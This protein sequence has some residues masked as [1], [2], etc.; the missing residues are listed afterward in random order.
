MTA[1]SAS[2]AGRIVLAA[3]AMAML[4][5][6]ATLGQWLGLPQPPTDTER[7][8]AILTYLDAL[9]PAG[10]TLAGTQVNEYEISIACDSMDRLVAMTGEE[11]AMLGLELMFAATYDGYA[12][13]LIEH[14]VEHTRRGGLVTL[15]WHQ[16][17]P[18][19]V[20]PRGEF[21][22]CSKT[23]MSEDEL[24]RM[25]TPGTPENDLWKADVAASAETL[26]ALQEAGVTVLFRPY[27]EMSGDWFWWGKKSHFPQLWDALYDEFVFVHG[28]D[29]MI[30]V[31]SGDR[32]F[33]G[34]DGYWP[35]R[36]PP[37][38]VGT[39]VYEASDTSP[40]Y[41]AALP[42]L[43]SL[44][45]DLPFAFTEVGKAPAPGVMEAT[46]PAWVLLWGG[47]FLNA[48][49]VQT[50][51]CSSCNTEEAVKAF[52][53]ND[54]IVALADMPAD[55]RRIIAGRH[56]TAPENRPVCPSPLLDPTE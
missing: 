2:R 48:N 30:W 6:C 33:E 1:K 45:P 19:H 36:H 26:K 18:L 46:S 31:W 41:T 42:A 23:A 34:A 11:P 49:W 39:D 51:D 7:R 47:E 25:L 55:L 8:E 10:Q 5:A 16:R 38:V 29:S 13:R 14:A 32:A 53:A 22:D 24:V 21:Y 40:N 9:G 50:W 17:N 20:C 4:S 37:D 12:D 28:I 44:A 3:A 43:R 15:A 52:F 56:P 54:R 27:H 35:V